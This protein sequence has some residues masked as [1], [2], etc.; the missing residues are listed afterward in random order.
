MTGLTALKPYPAYKPSG[1]EWLGSIPA[2]WESRRLKYSVQS[3][4]KITYGIV[5]CGPDVDGGVPYIR[6]VDMADEAGARL[7]DLQ[8]T[9]FEIAFA[10]RRSTVRQGDLV[11]SI[12]PSF[13]KVMVVTPELEGANLTQGTARVAVADVSDSRYLFW[14]LRST[15][16]HQEWDAATA[17][18]TF[19]ALTLELLSD[20]H[21]ASPPL[22][23]QRAI[24]AFLDRETRRID[25]LV[26]KKEW[27]VE[28]L[29]EKRAALI[30]HAVTKGLDPNVRL[31]DSGIEWLGSIPEHWRV[32]RLAMAASKITNGFVGPTRDILVDGGVRYLQSLHIKRGEIVFD[33]PYFVTERWS[34]EHAKSVL[35]ARDV[36]IV[37][38]GD[39]GQCAVVTP[40]FEGCNCHALIIVRLKRGLGSGAYLSALLR[41][42]YGRQALLTTKTGATLPHLECGKVRDIVVPLPSPDEQNTIMQ[43]IDRETARIGA[44]VEKVRRSVELLKEYRTALVSAAVT[45]KIDV[46]KDAV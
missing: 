17:G 7:A 36:L 11:V 16:T 21:V 39:L 5:Q 30:S 14:A 9:T 29:R 41:S 37:Q 10:Y 22:P 33:K 26:E 24:A 46:R 34:E 1:V 27:L 6:P 4:R 38:T 15:G 19:S 45:G 8:R 40:D 3:T 35:R 18:A 13:G 31:K 2:Q 28:L 23:E 32:K 44:M 12:G 43:F 20:T 42:D 25:A